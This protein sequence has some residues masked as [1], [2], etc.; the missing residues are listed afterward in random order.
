M[1]VRHVK[2]LMQLASK[3]GDV[4]VRFRDV[5][6]GKYAI[7]ANVNQDHLPHLLF[8]H[9]A[10]VRT[11]HVCMVVV[12]HTQTV[13]WSF[14]LKDSNVWEADVFQ[15]KVIAILNKIANNF[16]FAQGTNA[17]IVAR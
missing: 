15:T 10:I 17:Q 1:H 11:G 5:P 14:A 13:H 4:V 16:N 3:M 2:T 9:L 12:F 8:Q 7:M 6:K